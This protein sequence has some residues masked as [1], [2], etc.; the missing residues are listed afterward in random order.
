METAER[1]HTHGARGVV[2]HG[3]FAYD[4]LVWAITLGREDALRDKMLGFARLAEGEAVLDVGCGTGTLAMRAK[5]RVGAAGS[6]FGAD[7]SPEMIARATAKA[8]RRG[9][10][11]TFETAPAQ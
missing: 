10:A 9:L 3:A 4:L 8:R 7:A 2:L 1:G 6:V 5:E 11:V